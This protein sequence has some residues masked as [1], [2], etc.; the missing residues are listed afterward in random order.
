[1]SVVEHR[2]GLM[3]PTNLRPAYVFIGAILMV[4]GVLW[5]RVL[6]EGAAPK[7]NVLASCSLGL[8]EMGVENTRRELGT[9]WAGVGFIWRV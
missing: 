3:D 6:K 2:V 7:A 4:A 5:L 8:V 1:M 9:S